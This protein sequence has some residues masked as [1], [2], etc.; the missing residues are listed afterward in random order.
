VSGPPEPFQPEEWSPATS[1]P[2]EVFTPEG[3][4]KQAGAFARGLTNRD[5]RLKA[6]RR[7][8]W[9]SALAIIGIGIAVIVVVAVAAA[10]L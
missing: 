10:I 4:I 9:R 5:P 7:G 8:M 3:Q 6:Y 1:K 2:G